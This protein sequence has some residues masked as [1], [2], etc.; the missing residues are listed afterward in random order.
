[1]AVDGRYE[2]SP[3]A[4][5]PGASGRGTSA[6]R[7][8]PLA[9]PRRTA[10][11]AGSRAGATCTL[12]WR[13]VTV[14]G[15]RVAYG[16]AGSG[17][18]A[19]FLHGWGLRPNSYRRPLLSMA[20][21]GCRVFA[22][23]MPGFG[24]THELEVSE[25][26]FDGYGRWVGRFLDAVGVGDVALA[27]GHSFGG[28]VSTSFVHADPERAASLLLANAV[29][30]PTWA[31]FPGEL[32][33]MVQRPVWDWVH[34]MSADV[35]A[36]PGLVRLLPLLAEDFVPN[37]VHNPLGM[38]RA[39]QFIRHADL[40]AEVRTIAAVGIPVVV[41]WSDRDRLVPRS[42]FDDLRHAAGVDGV[43]VE[44]RHT[45]LI[46]DPVRFG[47]LALSAL[48]QSGVLTAHAAPDRGD[49]AASAC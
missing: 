20:T 10:P 24:G 30:G 34:Q 41:V 5:A 46:S 36:S 27:A 16:V 11:E 42:A 8:T 3:G 17:P 23:A 19:L 48:V 12:E 44:G 9:V 39:G 2:R 25:R 37:L 14:D 28:G 13:D 21:A 43:V 38:F 29:G 1:M 40:V 18:A 7:A 33:T 32:R 15:H 49:E 35:V 45:W 6:H 26:S 31:E 4:Q 47:E 22:P